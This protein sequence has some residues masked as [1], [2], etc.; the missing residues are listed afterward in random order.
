MEQQRQIEKMRDRLNALVADKKHRMDDA[1]VMALSDVLD[2]MIV[3]YER[4][5]AAEN[6]AAK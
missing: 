3:A 2:Q 5:R 4:A 6:S 1:E